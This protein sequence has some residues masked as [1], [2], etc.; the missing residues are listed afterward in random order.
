[1][2][3]GRHT[4]LLFSGLLFVFASKIASASNVGIDEM[5]TEHLINPINLDADLAPRSNP[6]LAQS[7]SPNATVQRPINSVFS[8]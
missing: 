6:P 7:V 4:L 8:V 2:H 1:M 3:S 5:K